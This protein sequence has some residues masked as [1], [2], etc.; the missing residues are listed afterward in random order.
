MTEA[1]Q[2]PSY[3]DAIVS[4]DTICEMSDVLVKVPKQ[5]RIQP[6][7]QKSPERDSMKLVPEHEYNGFTVPKHF[8]NAKPLPIGNNKLHRTV[9]HLLNGHYY[10]ITEA[11]FSQMIVCDVKVIKRTKPAHMNDAGEAVPERSFILI[12]FHK[13]TEGTKA[14]YRIKYPKLGYKDK[15]VL[16]GD[17]KVVQ[18]H[19]IRFEKIEWFNYTC[20]K[21]HKEVAVMRQHDEEKLGAYL[22][23]DCRPK[24]GEM[25]D[26][27]RKK[28]QTRLKQG[29]LV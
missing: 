12:D 14:Q 2:L 27:L 4:Y 6:Q 13:C 1:T 11:D 24:P 5:H 29:K 28:I 21:C 15:P 23:K 8:Q 18:M 25:S 16:D 17:I 9:T 22:C 19:H 20:N 7:S 3:E 10:E 26:E